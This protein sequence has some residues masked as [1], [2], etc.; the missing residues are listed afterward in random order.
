MWLI[1]R[2]MGCRTAPPLPSPGGPLSWKAM[3]VRWA[4]ASA[5]ALAPE[6]WPANRRARPLAPSPSERSPYPRAARQKRSAEPALSFRNSRV[7]ACLE[8]V[9]RFGADGVQDY[10]ETSVDRSFESHRCGKRLW[11]RLLPRGGAR[12]LCARGGS[13]SESLR[14]HDDARTRRAYRGERRADQPETRGPAGRARRSPCCSRSAATPASSY[15]RSAPDGNGAGV[16]SSSTS[17][18]R[19]MNSSSHAIATA[20]RPTR[21]PRFICR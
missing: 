2:P 17:N 9:R 19:T 6:S 4:V 21:T 5:R 20:A 15:A 7:G 11:T 18:V 10:D 13:R 12:R 1:G 3:E 16:S 8:N 14:S